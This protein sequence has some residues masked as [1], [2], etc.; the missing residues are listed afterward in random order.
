VL[1]NGLDSADQQLHNASLSALQ[2]IWASD[3]E[4]ANLTTSEQWTQFW[5][6]KKDGVTNAVNPEALMPLV[7]QEQLDKATAS[8][9]E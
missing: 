6:G 1:L 8:H 5:A 7:T 2:Q 9:D 3:A 4:S